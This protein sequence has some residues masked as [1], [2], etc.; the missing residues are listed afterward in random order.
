MELWGLSDV[1]YRWEFLQNVEE[2]LMCELIWR[3]IRLSR[4]V[5]RIRVSYS[6][7]ESN[8]SAHFWR[9]LTFWIRCSKSKK[10]VVW[11]VVVRHVFSRFKG[12]LGV[13][14]ILGIG[15]FSGCGRGRGSVC[16]L[17]FGR[18][19]HRSEAEMVGK[20]TCMLLEV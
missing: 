1:E 13:F 4:L 17:P 14:L 10:S 6:F 8:W 3:E 19:T 18:G 5:W 9:S 2:L 12:F 7:S 15:T 20:L 11:R 16:L